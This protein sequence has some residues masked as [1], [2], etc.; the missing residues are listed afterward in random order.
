MDGSAENKYISLSKKGKGI[1]FSAAS[2]RPALIV[3]SG[4]LNAEMRFPSNFIT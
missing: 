4:D 1:L 2:T 3:L